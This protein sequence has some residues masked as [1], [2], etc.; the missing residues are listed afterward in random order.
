MLY[1]SSSQLGDLVREFV[2]A[3]STDRQPVLMVLPQTNLELM[4]NALGTAAGEVRFEDMAELGRNPSCLLSVYEDWIED[5]DGP[6]RVV[7]EP[8]WPGRSYAEVVECLRNEALVNHVLAC[9]PVSILCPYDAER[10]N[11]DAL[12]GAE[13]THPQLVDTGGRR[14]ASEQYGEPLEVHQ[15]GRWPQERATEPVSVHAFAGDLHAL[16]KA[17]AD[18]PIAASLGPDR[19][20]DLVFVVNEAVTNAL[21]HGDGTCTA[22]L[23]NDGTSIVSEVRTPSVIDDAMAGRRRPS[24]EAPSGRGLWLINQLCDLVELRCDQ[25]GTTL[26]MHVRDR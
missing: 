11:A 23:W 24:P 3:A 22:R 15:A 19:L 10:L 16:R 5:H 14:R 25:T 2:L 8:V 18:D 20:A 4:R 9:A 7:G 6:V 21:K 12:A 1:R 13:L 26:R 17:V